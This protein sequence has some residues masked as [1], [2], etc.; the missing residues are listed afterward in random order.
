MGTLLLQ[1]GAEGAQLTVTAVA[2]EYPD[3]FD[4]TIEADASCFQGS[5]TQPLSREDLESWAEQMEAPEPEELVLGGNR[6][7]ILKMD[8]NVQGP[9]TE[10]PA[11]VVQAW[12]A[13]TEDDPYP[14]LT[15]LI[16]DLAP[17]WSEAAQ[18]V[19]EFLA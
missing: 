9:V 2:S 5:I 14:N 7:M 12:L 1:L 11:F 4:V 19:R 3:H 10:P 16:F 15:W 18:R 6:A 13:W 8:I 17:F